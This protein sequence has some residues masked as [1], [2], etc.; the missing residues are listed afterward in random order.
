MYLNDHRNKL[1]SLRVH[2]NC[3]CKQVRAEIFRGLILK[4]M[5]VRRIPCMQNRYQTLGAIEAIIFSS[6]I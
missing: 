3:R 1:K 2:E 4:Y 5:W 6:G